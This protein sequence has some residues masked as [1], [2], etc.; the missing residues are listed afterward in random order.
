MRTHT[1]NAS[2]HT[3]PPPSGP[4]SPH[5]AFPSALRMPCA[6]SVG[7]FDEAV[8]EDWEADSGGADELSEEAFKSCWFQLADVQ[9]DSIDGAEYAEWIRSMIKQMTMSAHKQKP[10]SSS[11]VQL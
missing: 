3:P 9:T 4:S 6:V 5:R 2:T 10:G 1:G 7:D 11:C 8:E